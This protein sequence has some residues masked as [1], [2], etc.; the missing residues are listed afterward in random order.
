LLQPEFVGRQRGGLRGVHAERFRRGSLGPLHGGH[1]AAPELGLRKQPR[2]NLVTGSR[3][4]DPYTPPII[5][6]SRSGAPAASRPQRAQP[7]ARPSLRSHTASICAAQRSSCYASPPPHACGRRAPSALRA[8]LRRRC[9][10]PRRGESTRQ[11]S[12]SSM[13]SARLKR[14]FTSLQGRRYRPWV[15]PRHGTAGDCRAPSTDPH[16]GLQAG[17]AQNGLDELQLC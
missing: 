2:R 6:R 3:G 14:L 10:L 17:P 13:V 16:P 1:L 8:G 5:D 4:M 7:Q 15:S 11:H 9:H 12:R